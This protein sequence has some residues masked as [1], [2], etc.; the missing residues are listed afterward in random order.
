MLLGL[1]TACL[2]TE[3]AGPPSNPATETY[4]PSLGVDISQ[5]TKVSDALYIQDRVVG[6]GALIAA[7]DSIQVTYAGW[8]VNGVQFDPATGTASFPLRIGVQHVID[9]W[10]IGVPGM[11][12]GGKR[13]LVIGSDL[14]Y[15]PT[16]YLTIG[17]NTTLVFT[18]EVTRKF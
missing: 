11:R 12:V 8:F 9:G 18:V 2:N 14:A 3:P 6:T 1:S 16:G 5:M 10:D 17:P 4:A 13:L 15:G 7:G